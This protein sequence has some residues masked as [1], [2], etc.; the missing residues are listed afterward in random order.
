MS[1]GLGEYAVVDKVYIVAATDERGGKC[2]IKKTCYY[3]FP[4]S[5]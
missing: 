5:L 2:P 1:E 4:L 3:V